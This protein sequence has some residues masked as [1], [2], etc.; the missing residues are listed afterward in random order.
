MREPVGFGDAV[1]GPTAGA[2]AVVAQR[3][4]SI[5]R[6]IDGVRLALGPLRVLDWQSKAGNAF[7]ES[8]GGCNIALTGVVRDVEASAQDV[9]HYAQSLDVAARGDIGRPEIVP[10]FGGGTG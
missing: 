7:A 8:V 1:P 6:E 10:W 2:V 3:L 9:Q 4:G 5:A